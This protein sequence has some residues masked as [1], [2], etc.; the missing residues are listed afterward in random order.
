MVLM[1][2]PLTTVSVANVASSIG[3]SGFAAA[4]M[5]LF[6]ELESKKKEKVRLEK[7]RSVYFREL[8]NQLTM[9][10]ERLL[11]LEQRLGD[12][13]FDWDL[14]D[15]NYVSFRYMVEMSVKYK[16]EQ[17]SFEEAVERLNQIGNKYNYENMKNTSDDLKHRIQRMFLIVASSTNYMINEVRSINIDKILL[18][19]ENYISIDVNKKLMFN[20][21]MIRSFMMIDTNYKDAIAMLIDV[22]SMI[23]EIG[24]YSNDVSIGL[25]GN[26]SLLD[27]RN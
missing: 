25:H 22:A 14:A 5:A 12:N 24:G 3:C 21:S 16:S 1:L 20:V 11:W 27:I 6:I 19:A 15:A 26:V 4:V 9:I 13:D 17:V 23:R 8:N 10:I 18:D 7:V 2:A